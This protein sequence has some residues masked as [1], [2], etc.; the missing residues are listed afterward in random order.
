MRKLALGTLIAV[1]A[2][3]G[4]TAANAQQDWTAYEPCI[5]GV[6]IRPDSI[7]IEWLPGAC[8]EGFD[9]GQDLHNHSWMRNTGCLWI[10]RYPGMA[11]PAAD[12]MPNF[13][14]APEQADEAP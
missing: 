10:Y 9:V 8:I 6:Q 4:F 12:T 11:L 5:Y 3:I 1:F 7:F 14:T 2:F 13:C